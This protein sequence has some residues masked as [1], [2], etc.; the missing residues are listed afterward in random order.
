VRLTVI[1]VPELTEPI[2]DAWLA[3]APKTLSKA[4]LAKGSS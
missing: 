2:T 4:F 1:S 3:Q